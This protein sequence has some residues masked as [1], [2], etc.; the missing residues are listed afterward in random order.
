MHSL[1][2]AT[3]FSN[4]HTGQILMIMPTSTV[5]FEDT[6]DLSQFIDWLSNRL[7]EFQSSSQPPSSINTNYAKKAINE[8]T[9]SLHENRGEN[10]EL[11]L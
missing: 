4:S 1:D 5:I 3:I 6:A 10:K 9:K 11:G 2:D 8:W 7:R